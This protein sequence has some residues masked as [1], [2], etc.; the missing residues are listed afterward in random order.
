MPSYGHSLISSFGD[1]SS[2]SLARSPFQLSLLLDS[3]LHISSLD[4]LWFLLIC[5]DSNIVV[6]VFRITSLLRIEYEG[7]LTSNASMSP[8]IIWAYAQISTAIILAC[9]PLLRPV[10]ERLTS[11]LPWIRTPTS[12]S[13]EVLPS[14][15]VT[16]RID[17]HEDSSTPPMIKGYMD[18]HEG[19]KWPEGPSVEVQA[20]MQDMG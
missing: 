9:C 17:V 4:K 13:V 20:V 10:F 8:A 18:P 7:G 16:T 1:S 2:V 11:K 5:R 14:I 15:R 3:C 19:F 6:D 12:E